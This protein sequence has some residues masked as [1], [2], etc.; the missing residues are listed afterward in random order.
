MVSIS[1]EETKQIRKL[2]PNA[3]IVRTMKNKSKRHRYYCEESR[4]V[5]RYL[6]KVRNA[7]DANSVR[8]GKGDNHRTKQTRE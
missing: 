2:F 7:C 3:H 8:Y 5:K 6:D 4:G 1:K